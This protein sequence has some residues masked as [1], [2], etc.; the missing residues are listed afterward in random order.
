MTSDGAGVEEPL[1]GLSS[2]LLGRKKGDR[3]MIAIPP[4]ILQVT[5]CASIA[6]YLR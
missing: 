4:A 3:F 6:V 2:A 1:G 5:T